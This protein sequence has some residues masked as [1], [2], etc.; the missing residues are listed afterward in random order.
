MIPLFVED[1][2]LPPGIHTTTWDV[3]YERFGTTH[4]RNMLLQ[5]LFAAIDH[6]AKAGC[7]EIFIGGS[8]VTNKTIPEDFDACWNPEGVSSVL[9]DPVLIDFSKKR[10]AMKAKYYGELFLLTLPAT[11]RMSTGLMNSLFLVLK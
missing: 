3:F 1:G 7:R 4:Q 11:S 6:L 10:A 5:G 2:C 9:T 8:F